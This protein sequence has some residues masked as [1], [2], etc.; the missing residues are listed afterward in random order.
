MGVGEAIV[1]A[2]KVR[3][4]AQEKQWERE[5]KRRDQEHEEKMEMLRQQAARE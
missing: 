1:E 5:E 3:V 2:E 4:E